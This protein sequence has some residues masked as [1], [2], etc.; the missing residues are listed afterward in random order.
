MSK[1]TFLVWILAMLALAT[2]VGCGD[3]DDD[4]NNDDTAPT[5]DDD[6]DDN[7]DD[8]N[9]DDNDDDD[10]DNDDDN[11][12]DDDDDDDDDVVN[13]PLVPF[14]IYD[15]TGNDNHGDYTGTAEIFTLD[16]GA[17]FIRLAHYTDVTF[18]DPYKDLDYDVYSAWVGVAGSDEIAVTLQV[19][20]F[21]VEY[22]DLVR[23]EA[24]GPRLL[25]T[26]TAEETDGDYVVTYAG[27]AG[28]SRAYAATETWTYREPSGAEPMFVNEDVSVA[29]HEPMPEWMKS[30][31]S[32]LLAEYHALEFYDDYRDREEFKAGVHYMNHYRT[33]F[34][35][36]R[37]NPDA[38]RVVNKWLD[39]ISLAE[40]MVRARAYGPTLAEKAAAFEAEM[41]EHFLNPLGM[42]SETLIGSEPLR[43][44]ESWD[45]LL[46]SGC[47]LASQVWRYL[48]TGEQEAL[49]NWLWIL[50]G[51]MLA[52]DIPQ[53]DTLFAR[54]V[55]PHR[56]DGKREWVRGAAPY[57]DYD[58]L[59][60]GNNDMVQGLFYGYTMSW[61][62]LPDE[63]AYD[64]YRAAI[65]ERAARLADFDNIAR[66]NGFNEMRATLLAYLTTGEQRFF[67][68]FDEL[69]SNVFYRL[70]VFIGDGMFYLWGVTDWSGQHLETV[71]TITLYQLVEATG[72]GG[73]EQFQIGWANG[74]RLNATSG[75]V[76]WPIAAN[77]FADPPPDTQDT[78]DLAMWRM[79]EIPYPKQQFQVDQRIDPEWCASP[80]PSL[81]WKL[82]YFQGGRHQGIYGVPIF[83]MGGSANYF[84]DG[85]FSVDDGASE[86]M[87]GAGADFLQ[88]YWLGRYY[89]VIDAED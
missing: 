51:L 12:D 40:T 27:E 69:W 46:W 13:P 67:D 81:F 19:A 29:S 20:D 57:E 72:V 82:D 38:V 48:V 70:W 37:A 73:L 71:G 34:D 33:D 61:L 83:E 1:K 68:R 10:D 65:A 44:E 55:R 53:D 17:Q 5:D 31:V 7:D 24:D 14:G 23:T 43:Q 4:D 77:A 49:D 9:N 78:F 25:I 75:Q 89:G 15:I 52:H 6:D 50:E 30:I 74:M 85:P 42:F 2:F 35:W 86:W 11:N 3:D 8:D 41:P 80:L 45:A 47:Y 32:L 22:N 59:T 18:A 66:D 28:A 36:Y 60:D 87:N 26:A 58:W 56:D 76:L 54:A 84:K 39:D 16:G 79:R 64:A 62:Y 21:M 63:P 88:A